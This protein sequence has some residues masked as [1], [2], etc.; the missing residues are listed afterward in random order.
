MRVAMEVGEEEEV[1]VEE[2]DE[3]VI[4]WNHMVVKTICF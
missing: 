4:E 1:M 3:V 2:E